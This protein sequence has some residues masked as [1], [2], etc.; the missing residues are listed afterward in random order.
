MP[1]PATVLLCF[2]PFNTLSLGNR[3]VELRLGKMHGRR[4][5][6]T[7]RRASSSSQLPMQDDSFPNARASR[8][9]GSKCARTK[10]NEGKRPPA[11]LDGSSVPLQPTNTCVRPGIT[12]RAFRPPP[13]ASGLL[14]SRAAFMANAPHYFNLLRTAGAATAVAAFAA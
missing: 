8:S 13:G 11:H 12:P 1:D 10:R 4:M 9:S 3:R 7:R 5:Q 14:I 6:C 2:V